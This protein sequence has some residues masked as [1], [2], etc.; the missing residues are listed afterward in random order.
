[1]SEWHMFGT[2]L[3][4]FVAETDIELER[5]TED[6]HGHCEI[7]GVTFKNKEKLCKHICKV[8]IDNPTFKSFFTRS[9]FDANGCN[10][11]HCTSTE[12]HKCW[13][14]TLH[15]PWGPLSTQDS[16][17]DIVK[18]FPADGFFIKNSI[19]WPKLIEEMSKI[20]HQE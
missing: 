17:K 14:K 4:E 3:C 15:F 19:I 10:P 20:S 8:D 9:W 2:V 7:C 16:N 13:L 11:V 18:N 6:Q 12:H 5:H 1:M